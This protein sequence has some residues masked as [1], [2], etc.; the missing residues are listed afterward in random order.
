MPTTASKQPV[1]FTATANEAR[2]NASDH[3][4]GIGQLAVRQD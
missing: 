1:P 4:D 3:P 2:T